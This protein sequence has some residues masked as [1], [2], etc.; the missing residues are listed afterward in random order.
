V[1]LNGGSR[2]SLTKAENFVRNS[3]LQRFSRWSW[4]YQPG[5]LVSGAGQ[6]VAHNLFE[7]APHTAILYS[8]N[9][10]L[11]E[12]NEI[13]EVC[14]FSS[15]AGAIYT[16]RDWGYRG[17]LVRYNFIHDIDTYF[18]GYGVHGVYLDDCVSGNHVFGNVLYKISGHGI[19]H[20]GGRDNIMENNILARNGTGLSGDSRGLQAI[21][22]IPGDSWNLL[23]RLAK[24]GIQYQQDPWASAYPKLA[25]IP[26][27]WAQVSDPN[28][29]WL[30][31]QGCVFSRNLGFANTSFTTE[32]NAG[33]T[34]TFNKYEAMADNVADQDPMFVDEAKLDLNL[35]PG[36]PALSIPGFVPIPFD[37]IGIQP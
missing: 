9:E 11:F 2:A 36:S 34:G 7:D 31:P 30:Y 25:V 8:G 35:K 18:E 37:Q 10:H 29:L 28:Q 23:E 14:R 6:V 3:H 26:N 17:N 22:N 24:D 12:Y 16:G 1:R 33:G 5:V 21:N 13:R 20:G 19:L 27:D 15:D 32:S 4:T